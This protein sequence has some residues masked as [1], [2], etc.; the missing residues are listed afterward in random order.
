MTVSGRTRRCCLMASDSKYFL[1]VNK[2]SDRTSDPSAPPPSGTSPGMTQEGTVLGVCFPRL[3]WKDCS[4]GGV[5]AVATW[6]PPSRE[7]WCG[8]EG[9]GWGVVAP[10]GTLGRRWRTRRPLRES[11]A[12]R[13]STQS[14]RRWLLVSETTRITN[15]LKNFN[16]RS[17]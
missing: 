7:H 6:A 4:G 15:T 17:V 14:S 1:S 16:S 9:P 3:E 11:G 13:A 2:P 8:G 12:V 10:A 5:S